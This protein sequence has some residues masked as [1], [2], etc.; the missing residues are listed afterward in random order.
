VAKETDLFGKC[1]YRT[2]Q[3]LF[4]GKWVLVIMHL[5][6]QKTYRFGE[7]Q[8]ALTPITQATLTKQL[9]YLEDYG[10]INRKVFNTIPPKVEYSLTEMGQKFMPIEAALRKFGD[11][12]NS[13]LKSGKITIHEHDS[14]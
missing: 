12:Y 1:P 11:E 2:T 3:Q 8:R 14:E 4:S 13:K 5:L 9:R 6:S 7:L 10:L